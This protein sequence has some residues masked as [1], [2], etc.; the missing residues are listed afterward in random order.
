MR[1]K[2]A[3]A[4]PD[5][6][7]TAA[8]S[9]S[10]SA[11]TE[12][13]SNRSSN[14]SSTSRRRFSSICAGLLLVYVFQRNRSASILESSSSNSSNSAKERKKANA[15]K[16]VYGTNKHFA[17]TAANVAQ[18]I[19]VGGYHHIATAGRHA[20]YNETACGEGWTQAVLLSSSSSDNAGRSTRGTATSREDLFLQTM[21]VADNNPDFDKSW[22]PLPRDNTDSSGATATATKSG[23]MTIAQQVQSSV[24]SSLRNLQTS[25]LDA[26]LYHNLKSKLDP[27]DKVLEAWRE[28]E[29]LVDRGIIRYLGI[30]NIHDLGYLKRLY[31]DARIKP[32]IIQNRFHS[33]RQFN[34]PLRA[35]I[36]ERQIAWQ[37]FWILT[38]NGGVVSGKVAQELARKNGITPQQYIF[39]FVLSLGA[40]PMIGS[41]SAKHLQE[42]MDI[43][44]RFD[45]GAADGKDAGAT[46]VEPQPLL[47]IGGDADR[48]RFA[49]ALGNADLVAI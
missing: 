22:K 43:A 15:G 34:V 18:A 7:A 39:A 24:Q 17:S 31:K 27:Y 28:L 6:D 30:T 49:Q 14:K 8:T 35:F 45:S 5:A 16:L 2:N 38:G 13:G 19:R 21:F 23:S 44:M 48:Q 9:N 20:N 32:T 26:V 1:R 36:Q 41:K 3:A 11:L 42:D 4:S 10:T 40:T 46:P 29:R 25:Y 33:N 37:A 12:S 47:L